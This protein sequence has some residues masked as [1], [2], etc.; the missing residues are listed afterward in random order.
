[1]NDQDM[2]MTELQD[3]LKR[4]RRRVAELEASGAPA[5]SVEELEIR[6]QAIRSSINGIALSDLNGK[7][8]FVNES[9]LTMWGYRDAG[10]VLGRPAVS[11]WESPEQAER[12]VEMLGEQG[13]W[14]GE[15]TAKRKNGELFPAQLCATMIQGR[16]GSPIGMMASFIDT[17]ERRQAE[18]KTR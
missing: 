1:M 13:G 18:E 17:T 15:M 11:F 16:N 10:E 6:D 2:T 4:L 14:I 8:T 7:L 5:P 9:F 3:E 12:V